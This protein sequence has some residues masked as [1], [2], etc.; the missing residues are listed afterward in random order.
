MPV[1]P[2]T[3]AWIAEHRD[4]QAPL[5]PE[6]EGT[7]TDVQVQ[8]PF[9]SWR[10]THRMRPDG[11]AASTLSDEIIYTLPASRIA[12]PI[13]GW[14]ADGELDRVFSYR[15]RVTRNDLV[16]HARAGLAPLTIAVTGGSGLIGRQLIA[17]LIGGGHRVVQL[18][19]DR[20][21]SPPPWYASHLRYAFWDVE[22]GHIDTAALEGVDAVVHL[23]GETV[24]APRWTPMKKRAILESRAKGTR[25]LAQAL[26]DLN[27]TPSVFLSSSATGIYGHRADHVVTE[28]ADAGTGFLADVCKVWEAATEPAEAAGIRTVH[29]RTGVVLDPRGG[30]L[31]LMKRPFAAGLGGWLGRG[32]TYTPWIALDDVLYAMLYLLGADD[33]AGPVN[34]AAP[35]PLPF[36]TLAKRLG[37]VLGRPVLLRVPRLAATRLGGEAIENIALTSQRAVPRRLLDHGFTFAYPTVDAALCHT[38]GKTLDVKALMQA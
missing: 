2:L 34:L 30:A 27:P 29:L 21:A 9:A 31:G 18:V 5:S 14:L 7:F 37:R 4:Y 16:A 6:G 3:V 13:G 38:L 28:D 32:D 25:L 12:Q 8:G 36:K 20:T 1:G 17:F 10:H 22:R 26:A 24:F 19:R 35:Q 11:P 23:A 15:H 33:V